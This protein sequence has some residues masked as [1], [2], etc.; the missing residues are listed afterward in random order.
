MEIC[1]GFEN[2]WIRRFSGFFFP[3]GL[4]CPLLLYIVFFPFDKKIKKKT[5]PFHST[6]PHRSSSSKQLSTENF[7]KP[8]IAGGV[9]EREPDKA[10]R[11]EQEENGGREGE[12]GEK[13]KKKQSW[14]SSGGRPNQP[15]GKGGHG[16]WN[17]T[18]WPALMRLYG[19]LILGWGAPTTPPPLKPTLT[20]TPNPGE[21]IRVHRAGQAPQ[22][23]TTSLN[24]HS[25]TPKKKK[26]KKTQ[27]SLLAHSQSADFILQRGLQRRG[28]N[29][30]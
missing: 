2:P 6:V 24:I 1:S 27:S 15:S 8:N 4:C 18:S 7:L 5:P 11:E 3:G 21:G 26:P 20:Q 19:L 13:W 23:K 29:A 22:L 17:L 16:G 25:L 10:A 28:T 12:G 14:I 9:S 30:S